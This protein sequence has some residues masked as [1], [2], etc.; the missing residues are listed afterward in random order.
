MKSFAVPVGMTA[1]EV[2]AALGQ[3]LALVTPDP[4]PAP[5]VLSLIHI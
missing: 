3:D 1:E 5:Q 4:V 2:L